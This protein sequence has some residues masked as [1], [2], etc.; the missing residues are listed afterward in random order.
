[1]QYIYGTDGDRQI[2]KTVGATHTDFNGFLSTSRETEGVTT[3]D[4]CRIVDHYKSDE[5]AEGNCYDWYT[6]T[7]RYHYEDRQEDSV[8]KDDTI[9]EILEMIANHD[10]VIAEIMEMLGGQK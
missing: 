5:D 7:D 9:A 4:R 3:I 6:I 10:D 1:M 2:L 8:S